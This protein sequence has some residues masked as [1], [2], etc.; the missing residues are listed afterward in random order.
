MN[1]TWRYAAAFLLFS[2]VS[3]V[4]D[5]YQILEVQKSATQKE[6]KKAFRNLAIQYH[7]DKNPDADPSIFMEIKEG[8]FLPYGA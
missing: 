4:K 7:P 6:I 3:C 1:S 5:Y 8:N 2:V